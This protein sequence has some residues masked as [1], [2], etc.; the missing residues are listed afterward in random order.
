MSGHTHETCD[1]RVHCHHKLPTHCLCGL[2]S[3]DLRQKYLDPALVFVRGRDDNRIIH[4]IQPK[5]ERPIS[6]HRYSFKWPDAKHHP[7]PYEKPRSPIQFKPVSEYERQ[8][9]Q[10]RKCPEPQQWSKGIVERIFEK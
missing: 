4:F 6:E 10:A 9:P 5:Y 3:E 8:F 1:A 2:K 7:M